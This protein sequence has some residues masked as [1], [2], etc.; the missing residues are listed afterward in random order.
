M[1]DPAQWS[2]FLIFFGLLAFYFANIRRL[3]YDGQTPYWRNLVSFLNLAVTALLALDVHQPVHLPAAVARGAELLGPGA[4]PPEA[5]VD[6]LGEV[7]LRLGDLAGGDRGPGRPERPDAPD[8]PRDHR[9]AHGD[10]GRALPG[11][12]GDQRRPGGPAAEPQGE[13]PLE[14]RRRVRRDAEPAR[15]PG[16]HRLDRRRPWPCPATST[17]P[18][19]TPS[20]SATVALSEGQFRFWLGLAIVASLVVGA[21]GTIVPLRIGIKAF[22]K[23]EL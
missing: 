9:A 1:R 20:T 5:R 3:S 14:D 8:G 11:P 15:Q 10:G 19:A 17:S 16:L 13:R 12:L 4:P 6:P 21:I 7:R 23:M 2:Q 18:A 22:Q